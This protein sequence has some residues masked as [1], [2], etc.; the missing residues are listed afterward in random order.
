MLDWTSLILSYFVCYAIGGIP[1]GFLI[2]RLHGV[3]IRVHGSGNIGATNL[4]RVCGKRSGY[5][6]FLLDALKGFLPVFIFGILYPSTGSADVAYIPIISVLGVISGHIWSP[7]LRFKG[8]K[9][10]AT[11]AGAILAMAPLPILLSVMLWYIV[12]SISRYVSLAS[13]S[14]AIALPITGF[15]LNQ[16]PVPKIPKLAESTIIL[17]VVLAT[18]VVIKHRTNIKRLLQGTEHKFIKESEECHENHCA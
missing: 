12:F 15:A 4:L 10:V 3:D 6:C 17:L 7:Y 16:F 13:I 18:V 11:S 2:G 5:L 1:F 8:G 9:G 14:A